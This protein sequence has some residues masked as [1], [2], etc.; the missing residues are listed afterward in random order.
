MWISRS[1][2]PLNREQ[3]IAAKPLRA[4]SA[5]LERK[6]KSALVKVPIRGNWLFR[7]PK[8]ATRSFE[9]DEMGLFVWERCDGS[10]TI[11]EIYQALAS[12][13]HLNLRDAELATLKFL[14]MLARKGLIG[15]AA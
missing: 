15:V 14:G 11:E 9:L 10:A 4:S 8:S 3:Q 5:T 6:D 1:K 12:H 7:P 2:S 13:Y